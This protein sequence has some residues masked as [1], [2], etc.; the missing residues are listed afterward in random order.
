MKNVTLYYE[1]MDDNRWGSKWGSRDPGFYLQMTRMALVMQILKRRKVLWSPIPMFTCGLTPANE[2]NLENKSYLM[3][4]IF[5][6]DYYYFS[7]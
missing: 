1:V 5:S 6:I 2:S 4:N 3:P 7:S